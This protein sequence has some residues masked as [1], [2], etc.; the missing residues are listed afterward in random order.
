MNLAYPSRRAV[1]A[2]VASVVAVVP[3]AGVFAQSRNCP[4]SRDQVI[5]VTPGRPTFIQLDV[6]NADNAQIT[7]FQYPLGGVLQQSGGSATEFT[8]LPQESFNGSTEFTYRVTPPFDCPRTV[9]LGRVRLIGGFSDSTA[10]GLVPTVPHGV[11]GIGLFAPLAL[12]AL[13]A[14]AVTTTRR[15]RMRK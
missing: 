13:S 6:S 15:R 9:Q 3:T 11:C 1:F 5:A 4:E 7:I 2:F 14:L 10:A 12:T 8:F